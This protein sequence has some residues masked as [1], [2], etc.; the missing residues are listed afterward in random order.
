[1]TWL[2]PAPIAATI[3]PSVLLLMFVTVPAAVPFCVI[4]E[5]AEGDAKPVNSG[6]LIPPAVSTTFHSS[7]LAVAPFVHAGGVI[8][9]LAGAAPSTSTSTPLPSNDRLP[10]ARLEGVPAVPPVTSPPSPVKSAFQAPAAVLVYVI[11]AIWGAPS[12][13]KI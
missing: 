10:V 7:V 6:L 2:C 3:E 5:V 13:S 9:T 4:D 11:V 12:E 1:M 8:D